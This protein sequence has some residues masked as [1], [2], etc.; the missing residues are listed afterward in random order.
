MLNQDKTILIEGPAGQLEILPVD[1]KANITAVICHPHPLQSGTMTNKVVTTL[2]RTFA[3]LHCNT[4]RFNFRGV[5]KSDGQ[6]AD[7]VGE[8]ADLLAVVA[9]A[10]QAFASKILWL[11][12]FSFGGWIATKAAIQLM[13]QK[14]I[15]IAPMFSR[16]QHEN[17]ADLTTDWL[18]VQGEQDELI[19]AAASFAWAENLPNPPKFISFPETGHFFHGKLGLLRERL[20]QELGVS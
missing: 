5:G 10:E 16:L 20:T 14:L 19:D 4:V 6:Y 11:A 7:G 15:T 3:D 12:G 2:A 9:W 1:A 18:L 17:L 8:L 13:P